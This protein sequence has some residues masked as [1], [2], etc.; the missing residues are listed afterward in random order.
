MQLPSLSALISGWQ[1]E[2]SP[3]LPRVIC[4]ASVLQV[5]VS[6]RYL[7]WSGRIC[8]VHVVCAPCIVFQSIGHLGISRAII[9]I[10]QIVVNVRI[11]KVVEV[12]GWRSGSINFVTCF[13]LDGRKDNHELVAQIHVL[14][15]EVSLRRR[16]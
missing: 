7:N 3:S 4:S 9:A 1:I 6:M 16:C 10:Q 14:C 5:T 15:L 2:A 13:T 11:C 8:S 12:S